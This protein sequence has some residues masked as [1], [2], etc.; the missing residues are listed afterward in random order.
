MQNVIDKIQLTTESVKF[1]ILWSHCLGS[2]NPADL[3]TRGL[4]SLEL[5]V[6]QLWRIGP[7]WL[8]AGFEPSTVSNVQSMPRNVLWS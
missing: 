3:P 5:S 1:A 6:S 8:Q 4:I 2:S 7:E